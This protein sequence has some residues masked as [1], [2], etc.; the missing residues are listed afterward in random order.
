MTP[1][2]GDIRRALKWQQNNAPN[3]AS[4][5]NQKY[6]WYSQFNTTFWVNWQKNIFDLRTASPFGIMVWC[7]ILN[8]PS[9]LFGLYNTPL[10]FAYG[11]KRQNYK[12]NPSISGYNRLGGNFIG[13][14]STALLNMDE[15]RKA[16]RI[17]FYAL[18]SNSSL[19][20]INAAL[21]D[22]FGNGAKA[23]DYAGKNYF[24]CMDNTNGAQTLP[25][26][27]AVTAANYIEFRIGANFAMSPQLLAML[28]EPKYNLLPAVCGKSFS[29]VRM[30]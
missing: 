15:A 3:L 18:I 13:G 22:V 21:L 9:Q 27:P 29:I 24:V 1:Y 25:G 14:N 2:N 16:L 12:G 6:N 19:S 4:L 30:T 5:I 26:F 10:A 7:I 23:W 17:R 11:N 20:M 8:V 28:R